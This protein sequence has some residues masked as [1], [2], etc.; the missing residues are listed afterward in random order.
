MLS[1]QVR[2]FLVE[3]LKTKC[4]QSRTRE[5]VRFYIFRDKV[6][7]CLLLLPSPSSRPLLPFFFSFLQAEEAALLSDLYL[8]AG[9]RDNLFVCD[10][11]PSPILSLSFSPKFICMRNSKQF[12]STFYRNSKHFNFLLSADNR[13]ALL[14]RFLQGLS[15]RITPVSA[16]ATPVR[17]GDADGKARNI[18]WRFV[19]DLAPSSHSVLTYSS[20][21][22]HSVDGQTLL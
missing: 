20:P 13:S 8:P 19:V 21:A 9:F 2:D 17:V 5:D 7:R 11:H 3:A 1:R 12:G 4:A 10:D 6:R 22:P 16:L 18:V 14:G 15:L